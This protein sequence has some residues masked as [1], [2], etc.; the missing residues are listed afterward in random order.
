MTKQW[1]LFIDSSK[2]C[3]EALLLHIGNELASIPIAYSIHLK[4]MY[5]TMKVLLQNIKYEEYQR[6]VCGDFKA[7]GILLGQQTEYTKV[8]CFICEWDSRTLE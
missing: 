2:R 5:S 6:L 7:I 3:L 1:R 8:P 4:E